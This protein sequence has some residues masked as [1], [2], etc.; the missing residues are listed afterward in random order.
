MT[1]TA[2]APCPP[3]C[4]PEWQLFRQLLP[5][6][7]LNDL[8]PKAAQTVYTPYV[9]TWLLLY[10]RLN[11]NATLNDAV[12]ELT[13]RF[14]AQA[15][16]ACKR[17]RDGCLSSNTGAYSLARRRLDCRVLYWAAQNVF[18]SL[19]AS[20]PPSW[21]GRRAFFIDGSTLSLPAT[22]A[23]RHAFPPARN[24]HGPSAWPVLHLAVAHE[25]QSG[26][27]LWPQCGA[28]YGPN[29]VSEITLAQGLLGRLPQ[30]SILLADRNFGIFA[31]AYAAVQARHDVLLR[32]TQK[33][34]LALARKAQP[35]GPGRWQLSW[36]PSRHD[37]KVHPELPAD[38]H[39]EGWLHEVAVSP[40]RMLWLFETVAGSGPEMAG[41]YGQRLNVETDIRDLKETLLVGALSGDRKSVV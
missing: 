22:R 17:V 31:F 29:A 21:H 28:M 20:Y 7:L 11:G 3:S 19:V 23:L 15:L 16:P 13:L 27:A 32:L 12:S 9:V 25:L 37:R 8:D 38:A 4:V 24:Q 41:L 26:L 30:N 14:P 10:Q 35:A 33:R 34:F 18:D 5:P 2:A 1:L 39:I 36:R 6:T 40:Q